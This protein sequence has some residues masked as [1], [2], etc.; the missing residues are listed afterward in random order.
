MDEE[1]CYFRQGDWFRLSEKSLTNTEQVIHVAWCTEDEDVH[2]AYEE[3]DQLHGLVFRIGLQR[4][5]QPV[6]YEE[7]VIIAAFDYEANSMG[8]LAVDAEGGIILDNR[9][10]K[11]KF[12]EINS[13]KNS[14]YA[15][16]IKYDSIISLAVEDNYFNFSDSESECGYDAITTPIGRSRLTVSQ[17]YTEEGNGGLT[18]QN[19]WIMIGFLVGITFLGIWVVVVSKAVKT[20]STNKR[21]NEGYPLLT[22]E[23]QV[24]IDR[25]YPYK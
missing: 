3:S 8:Y 17:V 1:C 25:G 13:G 18:S 19:I 12:V 7:S 10:S 23:E 22:K 16:Y 2:G 5:N 21:V 20:E 11:F 9:G 15:P 4:D 6:E 24:W 14:T